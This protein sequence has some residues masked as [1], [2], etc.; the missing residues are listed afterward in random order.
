[1]ATD[2]DTEPYVDEFENE[3]P[4]EGSAG[5]WYIIDKRTGKV[6]S[7][8]MTQD[9]CMYAFGWEGPSC[10]ICDGLGHG[11]PGGGPCPLEDRGAWEPEERW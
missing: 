2:T 9:A 5:R 11:Y 7:G 6:L 1:M 4:Q 8:P 3:E 10:S